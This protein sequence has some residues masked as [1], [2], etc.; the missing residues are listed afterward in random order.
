MVRSFLF[1][2]DDV[3]KYV[4]VLSGGE[5]NRLASAAVTAALNVL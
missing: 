1:G 5:R 3:D 4:K 2:G